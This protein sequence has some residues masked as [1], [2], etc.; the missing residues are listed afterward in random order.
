MEI[1]RGFKADLVRCGGRG[2]GDLYLWLLSLFS[3][4]W[5]AMENY[6]CGFENFWCALLLAPQ[7][8]CTLLKNSTV[9]LKF[10]LFTLI[11]QK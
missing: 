6:I 5:V 8:L 7:A 10:K 1:Y 2:D 11:F 9:S 4:V 3:Q